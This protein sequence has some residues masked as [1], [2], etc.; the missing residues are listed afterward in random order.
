MAA[1]KPLT[2]KG[3][4]A[5]V[6][7]GL[8]Y[9]L[10]QVLGIDLGGKREGDMGATPP[11]E[12][13]PADPAPRDGGPPGGAPSDGAPRESW[14]TPQ[15]DAGEA[16]QKDA[17][18]APQKP[19]PKPDEGTDKS[20]AARAKRDDTARIQQLFRAMRSDVIVEAEGEIVHILP[21]DTNPPR[22]QLF[23]VELSNGVTVKVS[24][25]IDLAPELP[26][27]KGDTLRFHGEYEYNEKGGVV[28]WTHR[29]P[30]N[31]HEH[32]WLEHRGKRY[33]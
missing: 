21:L 29:D 7:A 18:K 1:S 2:F 16:P 3:I 9:L 31:R 8:V 11:A 27:A 26:A 32:G 30:A 15:K 13:R 23:L 20:P 6:G 24:H 17:G 10:A 4:L 28:H 5:L 19:A 25:N 14:P 33:E 22:H 12:T